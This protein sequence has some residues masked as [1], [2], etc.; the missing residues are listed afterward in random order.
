MK[1]HPSGRPIRDERIIGRS[2]WRV[3]DKGYVTP[4]LQDEK[5]NI[6]AIGFVADLTSK[7]DE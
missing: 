2:I 4:R 3:P 5:S 7:D 6:T 1:K